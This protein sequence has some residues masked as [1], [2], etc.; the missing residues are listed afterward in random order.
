MTNNFYLMPEVGKCVFLEVT[1]VLNVVNGLFRKL[2]H[3]GKK[4][5]NVKVQ[6][7]VE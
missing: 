5:K 1:Y 6:S 7:F 2:I 4:S 3:F